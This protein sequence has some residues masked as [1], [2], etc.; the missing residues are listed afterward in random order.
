MRLIGFAYPFIAYF[1]FAVILFPLGFA[2]NRKKHKYLQFQFI[3][4]IQISIIQAPVL[5]PF[6]WLEYL[7]L[8]LAKTVPL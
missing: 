3:T 1:V 2:I 6:L 8:C 7:V 4:R 5:N